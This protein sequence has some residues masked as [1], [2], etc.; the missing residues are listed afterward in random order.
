MT[1]EHMTKEARNPKDELE[2]HFVDLGC[3]VQ[4]RYHGPQTERRVYFGT[5]G[6]TPD[7]NRQVIRLLTPDF[8]LSHEHGTDSELIS[9]ATPGSPWTLIQFTENRR[10]SLV[11]R[12]RGIVFDLA[13]HGT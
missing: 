5:V 4:F 11:E 13:M 12:L 1:K 7:F 10:D 2:S 3:D 9:C 8:D 6:S